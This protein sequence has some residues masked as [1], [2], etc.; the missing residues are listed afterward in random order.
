MKSLKFAVMFSSLVLMGFGS[1]QA[2]ESKNLNN[3]NLSKRPYQEVLPDSVYNQPEN[4]EG[5]TLKSDDEQNDAG[6]EDIRKIRLHMLGKRPH[7][8]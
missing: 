6:A 3:Q 2:E 5:A 8:D 4:W 7:M 1:A